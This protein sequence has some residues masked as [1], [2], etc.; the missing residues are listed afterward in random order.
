MRSSIE[1]YFKK[2]IL[3]C[4]AI[5]VA[6]SDVKSLIDTVVHMTKVNSTGAVNQQKFNEK[7]LVAASY[8]LYKLSPGCG[9]PAIKARF[10]VLVKEIRPDINLDEKTKERYMA[11]RVARDYLLNKEK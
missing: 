6:V 5:S 11:I 3:L 9:Q 8:R 4:E 2:G 10:N 1:V 7:E